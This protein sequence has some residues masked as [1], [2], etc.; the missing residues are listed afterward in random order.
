MNFEFDTKY[1]WRL[2]KKSWAYSLMCAAVVALSVGLAVWTW[3]VV[4]AQWLRPLGLRDSQNWFSVMIGNDAAATPQA[5]VDFYTYQE[6]LKENRSAD[7]VG[8]FTWQR[9]I[10]SEGQ[11]SSSLR[12]S[13][14]SPRLLAGTVPLM[15]RTFEESDAKPGAT[16]VAVLTYDTW[17][18]YFAGDK[19]IIGRTTRIDATPVQIVGVMPQ[20]FWAFED[21]E[22]WQPLQ[23]PVMTRPGDPKQTLS[24]IIALKQ[25][26]SA[27]SVLNEIKSTVAHVNSNYPSVYNASR[28]VLLVPAHRM[29]TYSATPIIAMLMFM[30]IAVLLLG[31]VNISMVFLARLLERSRELALRTALGASR[32]RL[33]RQCLQETALLVIGGLAVG[34]GLAAMGIRW[35]QWIAGRLAQILAIGR[36]EAYMVLRPID[37]LA[38]VLFGIAI[39]LLSTLIPA[40]R[41]ARQDAAEVLAGSGKGA[42]NRGSNKGAAVLVGFQV[43]ISCLVVVVC[44]SMV[45]AVNAETGKPSGLNSKNVMISTAPT[46]FDGRY[47]DPSKRLRYWEDLIAA[48]K[49]RIP[50][51]DVAF[52]TASPSRPHP[53]AAVIEGRQGTS[54]QGALTLPLDVISHNYFNLLGV[55]LK[56]GRFFDTTD[57]GNSLNVAIVDEELAR[58]YWPDQSPLGKRVQLNPQDNGQWLT[59]VGVV[60]SVAGGRPYKSEDVGAIYRP[61]LQA[62]PSEFQLVVKLPATDPNSRIA[63]RAAAFA[64]D[65]DLPLNNLQTLDDY[66]AVLRLP[67]QSLV[68]IAAAFALITVVIAASGL[69][70][71]I[72]RSVAQ[73]TQEVGILRALGAT[74][75]RVQWMFLRQGALY[76]GMAIVG[77]AMGVMIS[78]VMSREIT[79]IL[80]YTIPVTAGVVLLMATI[81]FAASY[82]PSRRALALEPGDALRHE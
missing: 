48:I 43:V 57:N 16:K 66:L 49:S 55:G 32:G 35:T 70:G 18:N 61:L 47:A 82:L 4:Y 27:E 39:W 5:D 50:G 28:R 72:S 33:L 59:I 7:Y 68:P 77:I 23:M 67:N 56:S 14:I 81:I 71:L 30:S 75:Q 45:L 20:G 79:N 73:R 10:L 13:A 29:F 25:G 1:A 24:P 22:L 69:F 31:G 12:A 53:V 21:F 46:V 41:V 76:L 36:I 11:A 34:Y 37:V 62:V 78:P 80:D 60:A 65:R 8:A 2:L 38:P 64:V 51:A 9:V 15:G 58:K 63:L 19:S 74:P 44:G 54:N 42:S 52:S 26:Q 17:R 3:A 6:L 40:W